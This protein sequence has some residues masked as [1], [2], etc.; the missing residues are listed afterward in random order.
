MDVIMPDGTKIEGVPEGTTQEALM[1]MY[2]RKQAPAQGKLPTPY[3]RGISMAEPP[4]DAEMA[5]GEKLTRELFR[6]SV[7][8]A[9]SAP[10]QLVAGIGDV[11][12]AATRKLTGAP[13][14]SL[15]A[16]KAVSEARDRLAGRQ[17]GESGGPLTPFVQSIATAPIVGPKLIGTLLQSFGLTPS[18]VAPG[19]DVLSEVGKAGLTSVAAHGAGTALGKSVSSSQAQRRLDEIANREGIDRTYGMKTGRDIVRN[20]EA[21]AERNL[22]LGGFGVPNMA[23]ATHESIDDQFAKALWKRTGQNFNEFTQENINAA[24][25]SIGSR[26]NAPF[27]GGKEI[28]F[29]GL[30]LKSAVDDA[31]EA[32]YG[33]MSRPDEVLKAAFLVDKFVSEGKIN[34]SN[35][36]TIADDL[37]GLATKA[38][39]DSNKA[40]G[41]AIMRIYREMRNDVANQL[42]NQTAKDDYRKALLQYANLQVIKDAFKRSPDSARGNIDF[43]KLKPAIERNMEGGYTMGKADLAD[44]ADLGL[45]MRRSDVINEGLKVNPIDALLYATLNNPV[46]RAARERSPVDQQTAIDILR[47]AGLQLG[48][49]I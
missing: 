22:L 42:P 14:A 29:G 19:E 9:V 36:N 32:S 47:A 12:D 2:R 30:R 45:S 28:P 13:P 16:T 31:I 24:T 18:Q 39:D 4:S 6:G 49:G 8:D 38:Y 10:L 27:A 35:F 41:D 15:F 40:G 25:K 7:A 5:S 46:S 37:R 3:F 17:P 26:I 20:M 33:K 34:S 1:R 48:T 44:L 23:Q 11:A 43:A 21:R